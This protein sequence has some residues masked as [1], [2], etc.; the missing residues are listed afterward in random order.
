MENQVKYERNNKIFSIS[1]S[2]INVISYFF[3]SFHIL[4]LY[5]DLRFSQIVF[6]FRKIRVSHEITLKATF[7]GTTAQ[8]VNLF[9]V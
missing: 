7:F 5:S 9:K 2:N 3:L 8:I 1:S 4:T 6:I